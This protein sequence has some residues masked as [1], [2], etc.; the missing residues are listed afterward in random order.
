VLLL[1][2]ID[3]HLDAESLAVLR[4]VIETFPGTTIMVTHDPRLLDAAHRVIELD[5]GGAVV[6]DRLRPAAEVA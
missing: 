3:N 6:S 2:E 1:D 5:A 4:K